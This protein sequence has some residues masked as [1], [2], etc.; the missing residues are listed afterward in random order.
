MIELGHGQSSQNQCKDNQE[1]EPGGAAKRQTVSLTAHEFIER[2]GRHV[3]V[4]GTQSSRAY[5][6]FA[7]NQTARLNAARGILGQRPVEKVETLSWQEVCAEA[8]HADAGRCPVCGWE[9]IVVRTLA[10]RPP[11]GPRAGRTDPAHWRLAG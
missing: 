9:L 5:G 3:P 2:V 11:A 4:P 1:M 10:P 8:G 6:L 7:H